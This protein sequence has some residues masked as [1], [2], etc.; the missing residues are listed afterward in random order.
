MEGHICS[1]SEYQI[2]RNGYRKHASV[3]TKKNEVI[4]S[5]WEIKSGVCTKP[6]TKLLKDEE[7]VYTYQKMKIS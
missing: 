4:E 2:R 6:E 7:S 3:T 1:I 5:C